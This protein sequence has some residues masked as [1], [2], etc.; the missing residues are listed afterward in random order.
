VQFDV[1]G[2]SYYPWWH[3]TFADLATR[4]KKYPKVTSVYYWKPNGLDISGSNI[5]YLGRSLFSRDG[6]AFEGIKVWK[7]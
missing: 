6:N 5:P 3:G 4:L 2:L 1:I 7:E